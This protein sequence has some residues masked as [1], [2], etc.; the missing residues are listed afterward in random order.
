MTDPKLLNCT[1]YVTVITHFLLYCKSRKA[2]IM[3]VTSCE[4]LKGITSTDSCSIQY[5]TSITMKEREKRCRDRSVCTLVKRGLQRLS[6]RGG[7]WWWRG[8]WAWK[9]TENSETHNMKHKTLEREKTRQWKRESR[10]EL[11]ACRNMQFS[12]AMRASYCVFLRGRW[13]QG[14]EIWDC[15]IIRLNITLHSKTSNVLVYTS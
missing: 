14:R 8:G 4:I 7:W 2:Q 9:N 1:V 15:L 5:H 11:T 10:S 12:S 3:I 13:D 6:D